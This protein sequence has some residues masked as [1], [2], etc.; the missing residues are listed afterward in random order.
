MNKKQILKEAIILKK[1]NMK[2]E[3]HR[4]KFKKSFPN[5]S[6]SNYF[7]KKIKG[8]VFVKRYNT[9]DFFKPD[10]IIITE[11]SLWIKLE[12]WSKDSWSCSDL[13]KVSVDVFIRDYS[14]ISEEYV[15]NF[16]DKE[17]KYFLKSIKKLRD[18]TI[19]EINDALEE[20]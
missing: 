6:V 14:E 10:Y 12:K 4:I 2:F 16:C 11:G 15:N 1:E 3:R 8:S 7:H 13:T 19:K 17:K 18:N 9:A 20:E 5:A